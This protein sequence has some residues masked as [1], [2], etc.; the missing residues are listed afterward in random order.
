MT[1]TEQA[2]AA[3]FLA[4]LATIPGFDHPDL[5]RWVAAL[6]AAPQA[7][8]AAPAPEQWGTFEA[9]IALTTACGTATGFA[10][11]PQAEPSDEQIDGILR[12]AWQDSTRYV[13]AS[14]MRGARAVLALRGSK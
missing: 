11:A 7:A 2:E 1:P 4:Q 9:G 14:D 5:H 8:P 10:A 6:R 13:L 3:N 12:A